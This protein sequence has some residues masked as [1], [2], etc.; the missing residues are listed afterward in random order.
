MA[1]TSYARSA[2]PGNT[3]FD[4]RTV[5]S[6]LVSLLLLLLCAVLGIAATADRAPPVVQVVVASGHDAP[7]IDVLDRL[8]TRAGAAT[9]PTQQEPPQRD[10]APLG[11]QRQLLT[12]L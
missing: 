6:A 7:P 1:C 11:P 10:D 4:P 2:S 3:T 8:S 9:E 12:P 5:G